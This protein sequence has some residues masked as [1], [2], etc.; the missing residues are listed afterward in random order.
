MDTHGAPIVAP[1]WTTLKYTALG[2]LLVL[3]LAFAPA[4]ISARRSGRAG[5]LVENAVYL[6]SSV[7][8]VLVAVGMLQLMLGLQRKFP[9]Q[10]ALWQGLEAGGIFLLLGYAMRFLSQAYAALKPSIL[11]VDRNQEEAAQL[12][13]ATRW[14]RL[15][16]LT[17]PTIR[18]GLF[19][20]YTLLFLSIAKEL[21]I[22]LTLLPLGETTLSYRIYQAQDEAALHNVGMAGVVLL[23]FAVVLQVGITRWRENAARIHHRA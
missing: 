22:T 12:L 18:P 13:G 2:A 10:L 8:G 4:W 16:T 3:V 23:G 15:R 21:P 5:M 19:A 7:P 11:L 6:T 1:A 9:G 17:L 14:R 20:A